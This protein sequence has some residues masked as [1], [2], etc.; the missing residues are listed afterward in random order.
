VRND[1][2]LASDTSG[3]LVALH[4][5]V[6]RSTI[7]GWQLPYLRVALIRRRLETHRL[8]TGGVQRTLTEREL[9]NV[10]R[11]GKA[12]RRAGWFN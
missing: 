5:V 2:L 9:A 4:H 6:I 11:V 8:G 10:V 3:S 12:I 1:G 7:A